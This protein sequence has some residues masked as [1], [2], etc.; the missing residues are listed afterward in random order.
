VPEE[1]V[2]KSAPIQSG[3]LMIKPVAREGM[4]AAGAVNQSKTPSAIP[5]SGKV[6]FEAVTV[7]DIQAALKNGGYDPGALDGK[8]GPRTKD[9]VRKFQK[10]HGLVVDGVV[11]RNTW[12]KLSAYTVKDKEFAH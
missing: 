7:F 8:M 11:G 6:S 4:P 10:A 3:N 5:S 1:A 12:E 9:A 2:A